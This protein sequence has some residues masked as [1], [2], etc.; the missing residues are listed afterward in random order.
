[1]SD[2][3]LPDVG[4]R[5]VQSLLT[6]A[7]AQARFAMEA[8][9]DPLD[10]QSKLK[11]AIASGVAVELALKAAVASVL[12]SLLAE[13]GDA[14]SQLFLMG[15]GGMPGRSQSDVRTIM[16]M[17][18]WQLYKGLRPQVGISDED[19]KVALA[20]RNAAAHLALVDRDEL[21]KG[22]RAMAICIE[23]LLPEL[24]ITTHDFWGAEFAEQ[25]AALVKEVMDAREVRIEQAR[26]AALLR[27]TRLKAFGADAFQTMLEALDDAG[28]DP[29]EWDDKYA[30]TIECPVCQ[31]GGWVTG[32]VERSALQFDG[33]AM[34]DA[35]VDRFFIPTSFTCRVCG[36]SV[37]GEDFAI[38][39]ISVNVE[40]ESDTEPWELEQFYE[41]VQA[42]AA[43]EAMREDR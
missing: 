22:L 1:M 20:V 41:D 9:A 39:G 32:V 35:W 40:L 10:A 14:H 6:A 16:G 3:R 28:R 33:A 23:R 36:F 31:H 12:P 29:E 37:W 18:A 27:L 34:G 19:V 26:S 30:Q 4:D 21:D 11:A 8:H 42:D 25:V 13:K 38:A 5:L 2:D 15:R 43:Y 17:A 24:G 7:R